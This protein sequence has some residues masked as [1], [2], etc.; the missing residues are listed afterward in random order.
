MSPTWVISA[1]CV[2]IRAKNDAIV[3]LA[4]CGLTVI[5]DDEI[6]SLI[7]SRE[8]A[9]G[10]GMTRLKR[11]FAIEVVTGHLKTLLF[12]AYFASPSSIYYFFAIFFT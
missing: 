12:M 8:L 7:S 1:L 4:L 2:P 3:A 5:P 10:A 6:Y 11:L 9:L